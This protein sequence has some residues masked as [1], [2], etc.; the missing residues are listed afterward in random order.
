M[1][2]GE[3]SAAGVKGGGGSGRRGRRRCPARGEGAGAQRPGQLFPAVAL[4]PAPPPCPL[5]PGHKARSRPP[6][7]PASCQPHCCPVIAP[8]VSREPRHPPGTRWPSAGKVSVGCGCREG[9]NLGEGEASPP[10]RRSGLACPPPSPG[11]PVSLLSPAF[12]V[13]FRQGCWGAVVPALR[14]Q[15]EG[16]SFA[17]EVAGVSG[18]L[19]LRPAG[20]EGEVGSRSLRRYWSLPLP[21]PAAHPRAGRRGRPRGRRGQDRGMP[22]AGAAS[23]PCSPPW[24]S[25]CSPLSSPGGR[26]RQAWKGCPAALPSARAPGHLGTAE[27]EC[28]CRSPRPRPPPSSSYSLLTPLGRNG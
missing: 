18:C 6:R 24:G 20:R 22:P 15:S 3:P 4:G 10:G 1:Q 12:G 14:D 5:P 13:C 9:C 25:P 19:R 16:V 11:Q 7:P 27:H 28:P 17:G 21:L 26:G 8:A 23:G 2:G